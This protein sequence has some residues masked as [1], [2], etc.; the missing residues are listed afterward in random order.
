MN[1]PQKEMIYTSA[2]LLA[3]S[4]KSKPGRDEVEVKEW[5]RG[6]EV[7]RGAGRRVLR[8]D[9]RCWGQNPRIITQHPTT[10]FRRR[11]GSYRL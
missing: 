6:A 8:F 11:E 2:E 5:L 4:V 1:I 7:E 3:R 10:M 9:A